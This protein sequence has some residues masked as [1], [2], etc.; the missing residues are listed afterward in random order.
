MTA[1]RRPS[2][3]AG[4][5]AATRS[6][7]GIA[8]IMSFSRLTPAMGCKAGRPLAAPA[9]LAVLL[10]ASTAWA[11]TPEPQRGGVLRVACDGDPNCVDLH[12]AGDNA[13]PNPGRQ[14]Q[15]NGEIL[16]W[17]AT[18]RTVG[19]DS[20]VFA[21][22][23]REGSSFSD[24]TPF[25]PQSAKANFEGIQDLGA[26]TTFSP[27]S[28]AELDS[29]E[30]PDPVTMILRFAEPS[31]QFLQ[32]SSTMSLGFCVDATLAL[33]PEERCQGRLIGAGPFALREAGRRVAS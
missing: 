27:T 29:I 3:N 24:V 8:R 11:R 5:A 30:T 33:T 23:L 32:A 22:T 19:E 1:S 17:L 28:L 15:E 16:P 13:A 4:E 21:F 2:S 10:A 6:K 14:S 7:Q 31:A 25:T 9:A 20:R 12:Q 26:R 18:S